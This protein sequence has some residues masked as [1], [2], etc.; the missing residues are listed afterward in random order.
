[1]EEI[2]KDIEGYE[3][4]YRIS[5]YGHFQ[6][7]QGGIWKSVEGYIAKEGFRS[8]SLRRPECRARCF[9]AHL[10]VA[11]YFLGCKI[12]VEIKHVD[13][14]RLNNCV[15]NLHF[16][17]LDLEVDG[18]LWKDIPNYDGMYQVSNFG[19]VRSRKRYGYW[20]VLKRSKNGNGYYNVCLFNG[21]EKKWLGVHRL[22]VDA[23]IGSIPDDMEVNH[24]DANKQN[25]LFSNLEIVTQTENSRHAQ[26]N[27]L[28]DHARGERQGGSKLTT[29]QVIEIKSAD[30]SVVGA[31]AKL[32]KKF[33]VRHTEIS[34]IR[35]GTR[36]K[37]IVVPK[38]EES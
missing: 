1:M 26:R 36:W 6:R 8:F 27:G 22:V 24:K 13:G 17:N 15:S 38:K 10:L 16:E 23:F 37:H 5:N 20:L 14:N 25:N 34:R 29:A 9:Y 32:A 4:R 33:G 19:R 35:G 2:W 11:K 12:G 21:D 18:E 3:D 30:C 28:V 31:Q 7:N